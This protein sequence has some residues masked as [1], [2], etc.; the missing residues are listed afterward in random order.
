M[1]R[2]VDGSSGDGSVA[3]TLLGRGQNL[4]TIRKPKNY[5]IYH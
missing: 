2:L 3:S 5:Y 1:I 4:I